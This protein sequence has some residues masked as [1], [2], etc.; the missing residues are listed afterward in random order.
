MRS[1]NEEKTT[2]A[3]DDVSALGTMPV[4]RLERE[5]TRQAAH[6]NAATCRWLLLVGEFDRRE[7]WAAGDCRS[8]THWLSYRCGLSPAAARE[9][10]RVARSLDGLPELRAM[11]A[12]GELCYSQVRALTRVATAESEGHLIMI[13]RHAS[14][15]QLERI[16]RGYRSVVGY[17]LG[18]SDPARRY[19]R[20]D[21]DDD[22]SLLLRARLPA[23]EGALVVAALDAGRDALREARAPRQEEA[24]ENGADSGA[25]SASDET[26]HIG[27]TPGGDADRG[28]HAPAPG[29]RTTVSNADAMVL[30]A[31]TLLCSGVPERA[32]ADRYQVVVHVDAATLA[33]DEEGACQLED[34]TALHPETAR[35]LGCD[36]S[37]V[38]ILERD[39]R[40]L[41]V[42][43]RTRS[44]PP[45]LRRA[46]KCRD[47]IC[48]FPGCPQRRYLHA[49]HVDHWAGGGRTDLSNLV[50]LCSDHHRLVH[51]GGYRIER[52]TRGA[53]R[54][55]RRDGQAVPAAPQ[56]P[57][58]ESGELQRRNRDH[59]LDLTE[60]TCVPYIYAGD[61]LDLH[62]VVAG[63]AEGDS[64]LTGAPPTYSK[65]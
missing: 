41:S 10:L 21:H 47:P 3:P 53:L 2:E 23:E 26:T 13:A 17:E 64:R 37:L 55:R 4:E 52:G 14:A 45:A 28:E 56:R 34:G 59:G 33:G 48:R 11:F 57:T 25:G 51:E 58:G 50:H 65:R 46:L 43:R 62:W 15:A 1:V 40:P 31:Q 8:C 60:Q 35:R 20:C 38:R 42:G 49:H 16:V 29:E 30:M 27:D 6:I 44:V 32:P 5:I 54:F 12:R 22:G 9:Q 39:G 18:A 61:K 19:V 63:L 24:Q 36:A 7:G